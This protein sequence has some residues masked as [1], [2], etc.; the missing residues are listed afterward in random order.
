[1]KLGSRPNIIVRKCISNIFAVVFD[2]LRV[3][4]TVIIWN[5]TCKVHDQENEVIS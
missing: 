3:P 5:M 4:Y 1:M 2:V